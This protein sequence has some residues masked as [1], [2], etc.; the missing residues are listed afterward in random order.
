MKVRALPGESSTGLALRLRRSRGAF[1]LQ[2]FL[3]KARTSFCKDR[4]YL[5]SN[6]SHAAV[7]PVGAAPVHVP[8]L[9]FPA[10]SGTSTECCWLR[11][12]IKRGASAVSSLTTKS[13]TQ[14]ED[15]W[16]EN[17]KERRWPFW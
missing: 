14:R 3:T 5:W 10:K 17:W 4:I 2:F 16:R 11:S 13:Q 8:L 12:T 9:G 6:G 15:L 1:P 7:S